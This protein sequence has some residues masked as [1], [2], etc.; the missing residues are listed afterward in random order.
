MASASKGMLSQQSGIKHLSILIFLMS[1]AT[2]NRT[3]KE[4]D[5]QNKRDQNQNHPEF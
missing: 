4:I 1:K 5:V 2:T 3:E